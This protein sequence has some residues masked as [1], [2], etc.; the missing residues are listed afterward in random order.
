MPSGLP[1]RTRMTNGVRLTTPSWGRRFQLP[2]RDD[3]GVGEAI[4]IALEREEDELRGTP[5]G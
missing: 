3:A 5:R 2:R 1:G 4:G